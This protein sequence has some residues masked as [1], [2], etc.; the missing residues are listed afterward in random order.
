MDFK[1]Y[2]YLLVGAYRFPKALLH[3]V[4]VKDYE[5]EIHVPEVPKEPDD[6]MEEE[7]HIPIPRDDV[8]HWDPV[9]D[10]KPEEPEHPDEPPALS[11]REIKEALDKKI[12]ECKEEVEM[13][14]V[15]LSR[16][17]RRRTGPAVLTAIQE[18]ILQISKEGMMVR[19]LHSDRAKEFKTMQLK[20]W[21]AEHQIHHTR[22]SGSEAPGNS[23]AELG[24]KWHKARTRA[25][26]SSASSSPS[27]WPL[28]A[29][30]AAALLWAK[31]FPSSSLFKDRI[32]SYGKPVWFRAKGYR[33]VKEK[34]S[35]KEM[36]KDLP[37]R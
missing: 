23:T 15:Y 37:V 21:L 19:S 28:A 34:A 33:G 26:L 6:P 22:T 10:E 24:V 13:V 9:E 18:M 5:K 12:D 2:R 20:T 4:D 7:D 16:P 32:L 11:S 3:V 35:D 8:E 36:N 25:L 17:L 29:A 30:H 14:T 31:V 27:E 1:D